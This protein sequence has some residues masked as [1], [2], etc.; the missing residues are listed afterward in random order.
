MEPEKESRSFDRKYILDI[1]FNNKKKYNSFFKKKEENRYSIFF[2]PIDKDNITLS[3]DV[4]DYYMITLN[5]WNVTRDHNPK[6]DKMYT[7]EHKNGWTISGVIVEEYIKWVDTFFAHHP[8]CGYV[9]GSLNKNIYAV[10][11][12]PE[13][14]INKFIVDNLPLIW[15]ANE[16]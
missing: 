14:C 3:K 13:K 6:R 1:V 15:N 10:S 5:T 2:H 4:T 8:K 16:I 11:D 9:Y 7:R 12:D